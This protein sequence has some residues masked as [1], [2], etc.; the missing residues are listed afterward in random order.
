MSM[1]AL[2]CVSIVYF[3]VRS[4]L[5]RFLAD[6]PLVYFTVSANSPYIPIDTMVTLVCN[7]TSE[8]I[9][10]VILTHNTNRLHSN[11][12]SFSHNLTLSRSS[13][14]RYVCAAQNFEGSTAITIN[15]TVQG[16]IN[17]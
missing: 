3:H 1:L 13:T 14:G 15:I 16:R 8:P 6:K 4:S 12:G 17:L 5:N 10:Y 9:S 2:Y 7:V 11:L